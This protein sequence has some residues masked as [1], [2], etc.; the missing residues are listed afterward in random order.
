MSRVYRGGTHRILPLTMTYSTSMTP[1]LSLSSGSGMFALVEFALSALRGARLSPAETALVEAV[2]GLTDSFGAYIAEAE[3][4]ED[5]LFRVD[6]VLEDPSFHE[7]LRRLLTL[8]THE[9]GF[10]V[11]EAFDA[12]ADK[13]IA[14]SR[15]ARALGPAAVPALR[16]FDVNTVELIR[17]LEVLFATLPVEAQSDALSAVGD[18][19]LAFVSSTEIAVPVADSMLALFRLNALLM[20][21]GHFSFVNS[22]AS[23]WLGLALAEMLAKNSRRALAL[24]VAASGRDVP[25]SLLPQEERLDMNALN[26][27]ALAT[28]AAYAQFNLAAERSGEPIFPA[29]P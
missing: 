4:R 26:G 11:F 1:A 16:Q 24:L 15:M 25:M 27:A 13:D 21:S 9:H 3:D 23:R 18:D 29:S 7:A 6:A 19:P 5:V 20:A 10:N 2:R 28:Q 8:S 14:S 12:V 17:C 22:S